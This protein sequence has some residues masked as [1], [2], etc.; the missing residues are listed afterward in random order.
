ME[1]DE[2]INHEL[3][4]GIVSYIFHGDYYNFEG[5][6]LGLVDKFNSSDLAYT[7]SKP[8]EDLGT[9][10]N[11]DKHLAASV[12]GLLLLGGVAGLTIFATNQKPQETTKLNYRDIYDFR[13]SEG[14][15]DIIYRGNRPYGWYLKYGLKG[16]K[17]KMD[18]RNSR[19]LNV[20]GNLFIYQEILSAVPALK[21]ILNSKSELLVDDFDR[22]LNSLFIIKTKTDLINIIKTGLG[23]PILMD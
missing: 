11:E 15:F 13:G 1:K 14:D 12:D 17:D 23:K 9:K 3:G 10:V 21:Q 7:I 22:S 8:V 2:I 4:H 5:I 19:L 16:N 18:I 20:L 6:K